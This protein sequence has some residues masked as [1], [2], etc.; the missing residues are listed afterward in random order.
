MTFRNALAATALGTT[1]MLG[2]MT[3]APVAL[4]AQTAQ[5]GAVEEVNEDELSAFVR[6]T[7][8]M[9]E[10]RDIYIERI[11]TA[12]SEDQQQ[13]LIEEG[14]TAMMTALEDEPG[15]SLERYFEIN[16]AAQTDAELNERI[17]MLLQEMASEG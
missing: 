6:A 12:E 2:G 3:L 11:E 4:M 5:P 15:M 9:S 8:A 7:L 10:V 13:Q 14:N 17:V 16:E 1:V